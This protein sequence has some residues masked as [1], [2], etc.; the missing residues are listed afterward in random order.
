MRRA[1]GYHPEMPNDPEPE[2]T[3][4]CATDRDVPRWLLPTLAIAS[5]RDDVPERRMLCAWLDSWSGVREVI[6]AMNGHGY[7]V[8]LSQ[9]PF[10][11]W[12]EFCRSRVSTLPKWLGQG[13]DAEP[14]GGSVGGAGYVET[15]RRRVSRTVAKR[16][17]ARVSDQPELPLP[18]KKSAR[19]PEETA[20][21]AVAR[22]PTTPS[23]RVS[24][25]LTL[26]LPGDVAERL[27]AQAIREAKKVE[28]IVTEIL[29]AEAR[30]RG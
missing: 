13:H 12:A 4:T 21:A 5:L 2:V 3:N 14:G 29:E 10:G 23:G 11:W 24:Y 27:T 19:S 18:T 28:A 9:S 1:L 8:R 30:R 15:G 25:T 16:Q 17:P 26:A 6:D 22:R 7:N 20:R